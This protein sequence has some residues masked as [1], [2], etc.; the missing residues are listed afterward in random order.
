VSAQLDQAHRLAQLRLGTL[1]LV[2]LR[3]VWPLL[4]PHDLDNTAPGWLTA[5]V[6]LVN[7]H[8]SHSSLLA[9]AYLSAARHE[10]I[11]APLV[12]ILAAAATPAA[13]ATSMLVT[14]PY[15][16]KANMARRAVPLADALD[17]AEART[18]AAGM[19]HALDGGRETIVETTKR[20]PRARGWTRIASGNACAFCA[21]L[22]G[23]E[24]FTEEGAAFEA[25][26]ACGCMAAP[27]YV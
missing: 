18:G 15:S 24:A 2:A 19:R 10:A 6:P 23:Q 9:G 11:G 27:V 1:L 17:I 8:R 22:A 25:H 5:V 4:D 13:V 20:D 16:I 26:D 12:P 7:Q 3:A 21:S 14:G